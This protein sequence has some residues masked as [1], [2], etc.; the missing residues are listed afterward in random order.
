[1]YSIKLKLESVHKKTLSLYIRF[2]TKVCCS[3]ETQYKIIHFPTNFKTLTFLK[4]PHVF[5]KSKE[6]FFIKKYKT[7]F[8]IKANIKNFKYLMLNKPHTIKVVVKLKKEK[9]A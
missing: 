6:H 4:S 5:K 8:Y 1:M 2:L 7:C 9:I 3:L